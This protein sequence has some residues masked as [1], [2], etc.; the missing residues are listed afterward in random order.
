MCTR[1]TPYFSAVSATRSTTTFV[2]LGGAVVLDFG[3]LIGFGA[4]RA[5]SRPIPGQSSRGKWAIGD[6]AQFS[7]HDRAAASRVLLRDR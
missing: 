5:L 7:L 3:D 4:K 6:D 2:G 1:G